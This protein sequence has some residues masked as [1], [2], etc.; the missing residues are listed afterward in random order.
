MYFYYFF[1]IIKCNS[2]THPRLFVVRGNPI[3]VL[4]DIVK[5]WNIKYLT[6]EYD[7]EPYAKFRDEEIEKIMKDLNIEVYKSRTNNLYDPEQ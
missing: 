7:S 3:E 1:V 6:Y 5:R 4:P 2:Y